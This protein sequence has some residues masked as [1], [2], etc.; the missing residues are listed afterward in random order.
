MEDDLKALKVEYLSKY[1]FGTYKNL[2]HRV[3]KENFMNPSHE[4]KVLNSFILFSKS[5]MHTDLFDLFDDLFYSHFVPV[6]V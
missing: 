5:K 4:Y 1:L 6:F 2:K 3:T